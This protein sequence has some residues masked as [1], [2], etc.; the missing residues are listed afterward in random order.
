MLKRIQI[1]NFRSCKDVVLDNLGSMTA[2]VGRNGSGIGSRAQDR[3]LLLPHH[4]EL[5]PPMV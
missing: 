3:S 1:K 2:L 4:L 5:L